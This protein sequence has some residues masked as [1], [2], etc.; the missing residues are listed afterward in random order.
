[1]YNNFL[2][3]LQAAD[4]FT[5]EKAL[6]QIVQDY[7]FENTNSVP[8]NLIAYNR[9]KE[10][11]NIYQLFIRYVP[12]LTLLNVDTFIGGSNIQNDTTPLTHVA[13]IFVDDSV[14]SDDTLMS[15]PGYASIRVDVTPL[16]SSVSDKD[17][18]DFYTGMLENVIHKLNSEVQASDA[19]YVVEYVRPSDISES[20]YFDDKGRLS[21]TESDIYDIKG[22]LQLVAIIS[23]NYYINKLRTSDELLNLGKF[24]EVTFD[25]SF[26]SRKYNE[27]M[28]LYWRSEEFK[29]LVYKLAHRLNALG[30]LGKDV[31]LPVSD[32]E[33]IK[34][35][36]TLNSYIDELI[37][38]FKKA[39]SIVYDTSSEQLTE[40]YIKRFFELYNE[41][42]ENK[43]SQ[44]MQRSGSIYSNFLFRVALK[45][46][47]YLSDAEKLNMENLKKRLEDENKFSAEELQSL[48]EDVDTDPDTIQKKQQEE[49]IRE[50][51]PV[52]EE[53][54]KVS[55]ES[56]VARLLVEN[57]ELVLSEFGA[58]GVYTQDAKDDFQEFLY[59]RGYD[60]QQNKDGKYTAV[61]DDK[62]STLDTAEVLRDFKENFTSLSNDEILK[63]EDSNAS[64][65]TSGKVVFENYMKERAHYPKIFN[66]FGAAAQ[67][68]KEN[69]QSLLKFIQ[70]ESTKL[71]DKN[72]SA[73]EVLS[74]IVQEVYSTPL[75]K[76]LSKSLLLACAYSTKNPTK[77]IEH[78]VSIVVLSI[79]ILDIF[80]ES[81]DNKKAM[82]SLKA[83][84][85]EKQSLESYFLKSNLQALDTSILDRQKFVEKTDI[86]LLA[87]IRLFLS[88][89]KDK[90]YNY[91]IIENKL[92]T[93]SKDGKELDKNSINSLIDEFNKEQSKSL[94]YDQLFNTKIQF[95]EQLSRPL[96]DVKTS[97]NPQLSNARME[98]I[99]SINSVGL[100]NLENKLN[101]IEEQIN[102]IDWEAINVK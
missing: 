92:K 86:N 45:F 63:I 4:K 24:T 26:V 62:G 52:I 10:N 82:N 85:N 89:L 16:N 100:K 11:E 59:E 69:L 6:R 3:T 94:T 57:D 35:D 76:D 101:N 42:I 27:I 54:P 14:K 25:R 17:E 12:G 97:D 73:K 51:L 22:K 75:D 37:L 28:D 19:K 31:K 60:L 43:F 70:S 96:T 1:M 91:D 49:A 7:K 64:E 33:D 34:N 90:E 56:N 67:N 95:S 8:V 21:S 40:N 39:E 93:I 20:I 72:T 65:S 46:E 98:Y 80:I 13:N 18:F 29:N 48:N 88:T 32:M 53:A 47:D 36:S 102:K 50:E 74:T 38:E 55:D 99:N 77:W 30:K 84:F 71:D 87:T 9:N 23:R 68:D 66:F 83:L 15:K 5:L 41:K 78:L 2:K 44:E 61:T 79:Q 58:S 81:D